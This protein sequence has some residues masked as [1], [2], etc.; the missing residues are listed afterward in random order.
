MKAM[1][2]AAG[3]DTRFRPQTL[4]LPKPA[5]PL[6][7]V[8]LG[9]YFFPFLRSAGVQ[10]LVVNTFH[11]PELIENL[12]RSQ[13]HFPV[14]FSHETGKILGSGGGLGLAREHFAKDENFFLLNADEVLAPYNPQFLQLMKAQHLRNK[15]LATLLVMENPLVG[16][17]FGGIWVDHNNEV[18]GYGKNRPSG[19]VHGY[20]YPGVQILNKEVFQYI[21]PG[22]EQNIL[23]DTLTSAQKDGKKVQI[24]EI[25]ANWYETGSLVD[26]LETSRDLLQ[27]LDR[28]DSHFESL[29]SFYSQFAPHSSLVKKDGA[30]IWQDSSSQISNCHFEDF[31]VIGKNAVLEN[32]TLKAAAFG[33][34]TVLKSASIS[35]DLILK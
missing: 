27:H 9:Y 3:Q 25:K 22:L 12:F 4:K 32:S 23:Y 28:A 2:L 11:L 34:S 13:A 21:P 30:L 19:A 35:N 18:I 6:L 17:K 15:P 7:N 5:I 29:K 10:S 31:A 24:F 14:H 8:P 33:P 1:L 20:H 16:T 26:Y